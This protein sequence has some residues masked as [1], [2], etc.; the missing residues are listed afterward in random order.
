MNRSDLLKEMKASVGTKDPTEYFSNLTDVLSLLFDELESS[1]QEAAKMK[2]LL[3]LAIKWDYRVASDLLAVQINELR[4]NKD[5]YFDEITKLKQ[6]F[7][8]NIITL[9]YDT[10][11]AFWQETLGWHPFLG[12]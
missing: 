9:D 5:I 8:E 10:F 1:K 12:K 3:A 7:K 4:V 11:C 6:A 2:F